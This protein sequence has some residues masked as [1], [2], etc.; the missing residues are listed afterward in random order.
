MAQGAPNQILTRLV[1]WYIESRR[2]LPWRTNRDPYRIWASEVMLQQTT[3]TAV[4]PFYERFM[5]RFPDLKSLASAALEDVIEHWAGLGY[6]S[7]ARSLHKAA[8]ELARQPEFPRTHTELLNFPGLGPYTARAVSSLAFGE[9]VG[10]VDGNVIRVLSR[11]YDLDLEWWKPKERDEI[12]TR[13]DALAQGSVDGRPADPSD[14]NQALMELGATV[15]TP[16]SPSCLLCPVTTLCRARA[17]ETISLRPRPK[18][19]KETEIWLWEPLVQR[20]G[21][22]QVLLVQNDYAPF[23]KGHWIWPGKAVRLKK[24]PK[25]YHY[26]GLVTHHEI[27]VNVRTSKT[28]KSPKKAA[29]ADQQWV[30]LIDIK[31]K[32]PSSLVRKALDALEIS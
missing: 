32:I 8:I 19:R 29:Q 5:K 16:Q 20:S 3:V 26:K 13:A 17:N 24:K 1:P 21:N 30:S 23:L 11:V 10:V 12:Q 9:P 15:C 18:P 25:D 2:T 7:R 14:V 31:S 22:K 28:S 4:I 27:F 6:Y